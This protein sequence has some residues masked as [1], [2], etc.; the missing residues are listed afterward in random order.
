MR[1]GN[2]MRLVVSVGQSAEPVR[3]DIRETEMASEVVRGGA[4]RPP[5]GQ[6]RVPGWSTQCNLPVIHVETRIIQMVQANNQMNLAV[7]ALEHERLVCKLL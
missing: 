2:D 6:K 7:G 3:P 5:A 1:I 4:V